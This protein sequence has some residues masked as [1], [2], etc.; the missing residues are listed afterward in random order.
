MEAPLRD[1]ILL[2]LGVLSVLIGVA[3]F[4]NLMFQI[5]GLPYL[6][7]PKRLKVPD[8]G[9]DPRALPLGVRE[10]FQRS[11]HAAEAGRYEDAELGLKRLVEAPELVDSDAEDLPLAF[12]GLVLLRRMHCLHALGRGDHA[13]SCLDQGESLGIPELLD[14]TLLSEWEQWRIGLDHS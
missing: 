7:G 1:F 3:G 6:G 12:L 8:R 9:F 2:A 13:K 10:H 5:L 14:E 11:I 4:V